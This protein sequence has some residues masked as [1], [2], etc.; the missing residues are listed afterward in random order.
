MSAV[1]LAVIIIKCISKMNICP[2]DNLALHVRELFSLI[3]AAP[4]DAY[5]YP[6]E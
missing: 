4:I 2:F 3:S 6:F 5:L 1:V